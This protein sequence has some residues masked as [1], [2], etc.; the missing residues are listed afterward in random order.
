[1][2]GVGHRA[3]RR[4]GVNDKR[5]LRCGRKMMIQKMISLN[6]Y[7]KSASLSRCYDCV[8]KSEQEGK[9]IPVKNLIITLM[10]NITERKSVK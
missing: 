7:L 9:I 3:E 4:A 5:N 6:K 1:M 10:Q 2:E 8:P